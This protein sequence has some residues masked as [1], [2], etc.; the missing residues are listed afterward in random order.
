MGSEPCTFLFPG[1]GAQF[2]G[3]GRDLAEAFPAARAVYDRAN[4]VLGFD[5]ARLCF[6]GPEEDLMSTANSQPAIYVTSFA[7]LAALGAVGRLE[8][9]ACQA[10][11]GLSL[12]EFTALAYAGAMTFEDGLSLVAQR[13]R[14]MA[15]AG[16]AR[17]GRMAAVIGLDEPTVAAICEDVSPAGLVGVANLNAPD[18]I[19]VSGEPAAVEAASQMALARGA[20]GVVPLKVSAAFHSPLMRPARE[21][22]A[23][24]LEHVD[25][26]TPGVPV[27]ANVTGEPH[28]G[29]EAIRARLVEQVDHPVRWWPSIRRLL[30]EGMRTFYEIGPG[31][32][33]AGMLKR[34]DRTATCTSIGD[35]A[36]IRPGNRGTA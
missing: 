26:K 17:P 13:G 24:A 28:G 7:V 1:Q 11:A 33:L 32:V 9:L 29:P 30:D 14:F 23:A 21:Q 8:A 31:R 6:A 19:V 5:L 34:I 20:R 4:D 3:M 10:A 22:L 25:L 2:V 18:Q 15:A 35:V 27:M 16:E 12:G 36:A